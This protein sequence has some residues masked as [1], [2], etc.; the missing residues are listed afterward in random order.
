MNKDKK[1]IIGFFIGI[2]LCLLIWNLNLEGLSIEGRMALALSLMTV[3]FWATNV[4]NPGYSSILY[5]ALLVIFKVES[6]ENVFSLWFSPT[7]YLVIGAY[8]IADA[9]N[10]SGLGE[11]IAY[12]F[13]LRF[14]HSFK[15]IIFSTFILQLIL[16][17][18]IPHPWPR[19]MLIL[20]VMKVII[21]SADIGREDSKIIGLSVFAAAVPT[22][23]IYLTADSTINIIAVDFSGQDLSW[24]GWF[25]QMG[26]PAL[27]A[28]LLTCMLIIWIFKPQ[29]EVQIDKNAIQE[30][31][32]ALGKL[33]TT[34]KKTIVWLI[35]AIALWL[36]DSIHKINIGWVTIVIAVLMSFPKIGDIIDEKSWKSVPINTLMFL[37]AAVAIGKVGAET[38][39]NSW[40]ASVVLPSQLPE[41]IFVLA[42]LICLVSIVLHMVLGSVMAVMGVAIPAFLSYTAGSTINPLVPVLLVYTSVAFHYI[43][44]YQH[45]TMLVGMG[46]EMG[47]YD[48]KDVIKL[49]L[50]LT[51]VVLVVVLLVQVPWWYLTGLL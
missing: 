6:P 49:G 16:G 35:V 27:F 44:P 28:S 51:L 31:L 10:R 9:V 30:R 43:L 23:M 50:P 48:S 5:L 39:M 21:E 42:L 29:R 13:I 33:S 34:E 37:S 47:M 36:T 19:A 24:L 45:M 22:A 26:V 11:R 7:M 1:R 32:N 4:V 17:L 2:L 18:L 41:N 38:G 40:I 46:D 14:V 3:V 12:M 8:L 20:S 15:S 25:V